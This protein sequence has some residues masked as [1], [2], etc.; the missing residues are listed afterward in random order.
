MKT[1]AQFD[2]TLKRVARGGGGGGGAPRAGCEHREVAGLGSHS[3]FHS[4]PVPDKPYYIYIY[5]LCARKA[6]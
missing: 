6:L 1:G 4:S 3:P 2:W 5:G